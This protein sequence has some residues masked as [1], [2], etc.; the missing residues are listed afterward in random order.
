MPTD[1]YTMTDAAV[2]LEI[3]QRLEALR[4]QL[5]KPQKELAAEL[6]ISEGTYRSAVAGKAKFEVVVGLLRVLG[7]L[8]NLQLLLPDTP[9]SPLALLKM[10]G[11]KRQRAARQERA[12]Y[13]VGGAPSKNSKPANVTGAAGVA[14]APPDEENLDW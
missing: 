9:Y 1:F 2:A 8:E 12:P 7:K 6:G 14:G 4:L 10:Q 5:N 13:L 11:K 3:G